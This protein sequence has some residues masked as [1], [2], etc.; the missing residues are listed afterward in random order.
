MTEYRI[1]VKPSPM[2]AG[3]TATV[4]YDG[5]VGTVIQLDWEPDAEPTSVTIGAD[6]KATFTAPTG[7][8]RTLV[9]TDP[10]GNTGAA[11]VGA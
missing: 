3:E 6:G 5:P 1:R 9:L 4:E 11:T 8:A 7:A 2:K 10:H